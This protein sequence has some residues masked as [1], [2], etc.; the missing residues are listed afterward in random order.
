MYL[1][2]MVLF[3]IFLLYGIKG[4]QTGYINFIAQDPGTLSAFYL[5][6]AFTLMGFAIL[7]L[8]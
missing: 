2:G 3:L 4:T 5:F 7:T 6:A 1:F 8:A